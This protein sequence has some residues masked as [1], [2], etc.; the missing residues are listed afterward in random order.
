M[1]LL[2]TADH[3][4]PQYNQRHN[5][6]PISDQDSP[7]YENHLVSA[8]DIPRTPAVE[9][10]REDSKSSLQP[11]VVGG[12]TLYTVAPLGVARAV[13]VGAVY[14]QAWSYSFVVAQRQG[15]EVALPHNAHFVMDTPRS[16]PGRNGLRQ[17]EVLY[18]PSASACSRGEEAFSD[19]Q[20]VAL[21]FQAEAPSCPGAGVRDNLALPLPDSQ[22]MVFP[23]P[24]YPT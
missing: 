17:V 23:Y 16:I 9:D 22:G 2:D 13:G 5:R 6:N 12:Y 8:A 11:H 14:S 18:L 15:P 7:Y 19:A 4:S 24:F 21:S 3:N 1:R 10:T 20:V